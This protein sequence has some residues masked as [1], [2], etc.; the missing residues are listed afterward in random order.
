MEEED[1]G[2]DGFPM[3]AGNTTHDIH[4]LQRIPLATCNANFEERKDNILTIIEHILRWTAS[5][6]WEKRVM[7]S[8]TR[9][10]QQAEIPHG[11]VAVQ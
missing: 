10:I 9:H 11:L 2:D 1:H 8:T 3:Y 5:I 4:I 7:P 6:A